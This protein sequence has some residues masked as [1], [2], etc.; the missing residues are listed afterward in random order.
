MIDQTKKKPNRGQED[1]IEA[2]KI[3]NNIMTK[4]AE[5]QLAPTA[6]GTLLGST[7]SGIT[8]QTTGPNDNPKS[9]IN[10]ISPTRTM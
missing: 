9:A 5:I 1:P 10:K 6:I 3:G 4:E 2:D 8:S 7:I